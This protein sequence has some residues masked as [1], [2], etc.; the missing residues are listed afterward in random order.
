MLQKPHKRRKFTSRRLVLHIE[1][2]AS[3]RRR[4]RAIQQ[5]VEAMSG[6]EVRQ[7]LHSRGILKREASMPPR[8]MRSLL[9]DLLSL[10]TR[11]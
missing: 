3:T 10:H 2:V 7:A 8:M 4:Q 6:T 11:V 1:P 9:A 5:R